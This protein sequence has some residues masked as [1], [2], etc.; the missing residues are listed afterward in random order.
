MM[1][2]RARPKAELQRVGEAHATERHDQNGPIPKRQVSDCWVA[3]KD[4]RQEMA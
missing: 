1:L 2:H 4:I 3:I